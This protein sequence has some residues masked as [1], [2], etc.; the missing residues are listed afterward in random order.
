MCV[1][2]ERY[3]EH[4]DRPLAND[5]S[6][7]LDHPSRRLF[8][9]ARRRKSEF[10]DLLKALA[11]RHVLDFIFA[12]FQRFA[13]ESVTRTHGRKNDPEN[14]ITRRGVTEERPAPPERLV[15]RVAGDYG[16]PA[17]ER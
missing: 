4:L 12:P 1:T 14:V 10:D 16:D 6:E 17:P 3:L 5:L 13:S 15:V 8:V 9:Q 2:P 7:T 11:L